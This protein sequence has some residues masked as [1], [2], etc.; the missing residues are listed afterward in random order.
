MGEHGS[1]FAGNPMAS[2]LGEASLEVLL[3]EGLMDNSVAMGDRILE[4][5][6]DEFSSLDF[7]KGISG[8][9]LLMGIE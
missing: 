4:H 5:L 8:K 6:N 9:G 3:E 1:T 7:V 2:A